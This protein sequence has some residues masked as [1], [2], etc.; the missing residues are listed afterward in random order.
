[1]WRRDG[2]LPLFSPS[3]SATSLVPAP[4]APPRSYCDG[5]HKKVNEKEGTTFVPIKYTTTEAKDV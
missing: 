1:M 3:S 2:G 5:T 4:I